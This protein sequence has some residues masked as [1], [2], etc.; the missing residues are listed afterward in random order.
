MRLPGASSPTTTSAQARLSQNT[1]LEAA[2]PS[3]GTLPAVSGFGWRHTFIEREWSDIRAFL[4]S[5]EW[6]EARP[7]PVSIVD[8]VIEQG[9]GDLLAVTTSMHDLIITPRPVG[10]PPLDVV[11]VRAPGS[12]RHHP[13]GTVL[14]EHL[15]VQGSNTAIERDANEALPL[16]WR[17]MRTEFGIQPPT[18]P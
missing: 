9:A 4:G 17:F 13:V 7:Y 14:I 15:S 5:V 2:P 10:T 1:G 11:V 3:R 16:F 8:S 12:L 18:A 6:G